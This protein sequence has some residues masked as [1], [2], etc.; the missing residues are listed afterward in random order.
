MIRIILSRFN[1][2]PFYKS[3]AWVAGGTAV[4]QAI[5][6][7]TTPVVTRLY[8]PSD[9]GVFAVFTAILGVMQ[10]VATLTYA[11]AI[12]LAES[13]NL[14]HNLVKLCFTIVLTISMLLALVVLLF[15]PTIAAQFGVAQAA[16]YLWLLP[17]CLLGT[18]CYEA[19]SSW[20]VREKRFRLISGTQ[21]SQGVSSATVKI[22][23]GWLGI[24]PLGLLLGL[25][26]TSTAGCVS[27]F[28]KMLREQ[29]Q[30]AKHISCR[31]MRDAASRF[32]AFPLFRSWSRLLL[33]VNVRL[34]IFFIA[35]M[36]DPVVAGLFGLANTMVDLPLSLV[37]QS[38]SRVYFA[39]IARIGKSRPDKILNLSVSIMKNMS[40][41][42]VLIAPVIMIAGPWLFGMAFGVEWGKAGVYARWLS[43]LIVFRLVAS[44]IMHCFDVL[45]MQGVQLLI[46]IARAVTIAVTFLVSTLLGFSAITTI[47]M[48]ATSLAAFNILLIAAVLWLLKKQ[49]LLM[50]GLL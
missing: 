13:D 35:A 25:L 23:L 12:P 47:A 17:P 16:S 36:F 3:V 41:V 2:S 8:T 27:I 26:A 20:A 18:G 4:A 44:P 28:W 30:A 19:L 42:G 21:M 34:P 10:P 15:G 50:E 9:Y 29:P 7:F 33:G 37:G 48:Y 39:E 45:E 49:V 24:Q 46:N 38:V 1:N 5:T 32:R 40:L 14:A 22:S 6:I 43:I 11:M 31:E